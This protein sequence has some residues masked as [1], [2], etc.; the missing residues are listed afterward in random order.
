M[1]ARGGV[2]LTAFGGPDSPASVRPFMRRLMGR[3]PSDEAVAATQEKYEAI[4]GSSP[5]PETASKVASSL[6][7]LLRSEGHDVFVRAGMRYWEPSIEEALQALCSTG[8]RR[9]VMASLSPF[10][11]KVTSEAFRTCALD[12]A[13]NIG[14]TEVV[15][16]PGVHQAPSYARFFGRQCR[17][18]LHSLSAERPLV[19]MTAHSLPVCDLGPEDRYVTGLRGV[20]EAA[21]RIAGLGAGELFEGDGRLPG[22]SGFGSFSGPAPWLIAYQS[23]GVRPGRWLGPDLE[24]VMRSAASHGYEGIVVVPIGFTIDHMET[25]WDLDVQAAA[26]AFELG[27]AFIRTPTLNDGASLIE[28]LLWA[29]TPLL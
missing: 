14:V 21:A 27:L 1:T 6:E 22:V 9:V 13:R 11:S 16:A 10:E 5:V 19:I 26:R 17:R 23:K 3:E 12:A 24:E 29:V 4:G 25:L 7:R 20:A 8:A 2:L 15:E 18:A 28:A